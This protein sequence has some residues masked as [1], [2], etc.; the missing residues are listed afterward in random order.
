MP[1]NFT[2]GGKYSVSTGGDTAGSLQQLSES[3]PGKILAQLC[4]DISEQALAEAR[5]ALI[6]DKLTEARSREAYAS[7][8]EDLVEFLSRGIS[9]AIRESVKDKDSR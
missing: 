8:M 3:Q 5:R 4:L 2:I 9:E 7:A 6:E 1:V